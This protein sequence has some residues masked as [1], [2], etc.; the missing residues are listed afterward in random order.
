MT[1]GRLSPVTKPELRAAVCSGAPRNRGAVCLK[2]KPDI[3]VPPA[4]LPT[5]TPVPQTWRSGMVARLQ[6]VAR[7]LGYAA[8]FATVAD[9]ET[10]D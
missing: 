2:C 10:I 4:A 1:H 6:P 8:R 7:A 9:I 5:P 3:I